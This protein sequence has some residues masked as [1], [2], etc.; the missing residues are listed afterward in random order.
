[1]AQWQRQIVTRHH[2][3][4]NV[5]SIPWIDEGEGTRCLG[6]DPLPPF[7]SGLIRRGESLQPWFWQEDHRR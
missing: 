4:V 1:M 2:G 3:E 5:S 7:W 6:R